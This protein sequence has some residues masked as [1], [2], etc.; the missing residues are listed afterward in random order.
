MV[1]PRRSATPSSPP[2]IE[3]RAAAAEGRL[4]LDLDVVRERLDLVPGRPAAVEPAEAELGEVGEEDVGEVDHDAPVV[5]VVDAD[6]R[7][8]HQDRVGVVLLDRLAPPASP[9]GPCSGCCGGS[10]WTLS[11]TRWNSSTHSSPKFSGC[12]AIAMPRAIMIGARIGW[13]N[14]FW[15]D[16]GVEVVVLLVER[17]EAL[18]LLATPWSPR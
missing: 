7:Q 6:D 10:N 4:D 16:L 2:N 1:R 3:R 13:S 15:L 9:R 12:P 18:V 14:W 8:G 5:G 17:E 11:P